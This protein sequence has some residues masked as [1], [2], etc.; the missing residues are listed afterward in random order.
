MSEKVRDCKNR[1]RAITVAFR[2]SAEENELLNRKV[3]LCGITKQQYI[4]DRL[5]EDKVRVVVNRKVLNR[6][7][8]RLGVLNDTIQTALQSSV[9]DDISV[10]E[11][12]FIL[13]VLKEI[14]REEGKF[15]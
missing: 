4:I 13:C 7:S 14:Q 11:L 12:K 10:D 9:L 15:K 6:L 1:W 3:Y 5:L 8:E 2:A